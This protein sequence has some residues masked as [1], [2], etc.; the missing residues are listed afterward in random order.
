MLNAFKG[1]LLFFLI[2][3]NSKRDIDSQG[4]PSN[5]YR[6]NNV[7]DIV[8]FPVLK[9]ALTISSIVSVARFNI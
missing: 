7:E 6:I 8:V 1:L 5:L 2:T 4:Y 9:I 3:L